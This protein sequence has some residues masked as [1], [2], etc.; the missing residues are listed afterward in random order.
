[1]IFDG[2]ASF[3]L[4]TGHRTTCAMTATTKAFVIPQTAN[5]IRPGSH[6]AGNNTH[7]SHVCTHGAFACDEYLLSIMVFYRDIIVMTIHHDISCRERRQFI[8]LSHGPKQVFH[9]E[10]AISHGEVLRPMDRLHIVIEVVR[11][12]WQVRQIFIRQ[13]DEMLPHIF[14]G[15]SDKVTSDPIPYAAR[16]TVKHEPDSVISIKT[17]LDEVVSSS[18]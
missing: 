7:I 10:S 16:P 1:M 8:G 5:D 12:L 4:R 13:I 18:E 11:T 14:F 15:Q 6:T 3:G 17:N 9:Q 2:K